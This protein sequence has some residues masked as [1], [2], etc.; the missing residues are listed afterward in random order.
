MRHSNLFLTTLLAPLVLC[1]ANIP[2]QDTPAWI[3]STGGTINW[4]RTTSAGALVACN[5][6]GLIG[7][8]P[9]SGKIAWTIHELAGA[10]ETGYE[11]VA[12]TPFI[13]IVPA[14]GPD[15]LFIVEPFSGT[16]LFNSM[17]AGINSIVSK[18][19]LY[20]ND[21]IVLVG[22]NS[23]AKPVMVCVDMTTGSVRWTKDS[24]FSRLSACT[25]AG[26][27]AM[28]VGT[29]FYAYKL[30]ARSGDVLWRRCPDPKFG[31]MTSL[32]SALDENGVKLAPD[33]EPQAVFVTTEHAPDLCFMAMQTTKKT[34][35]TDG[36]GKTSM[37]TTYSTF[38]NA[39]R[40]TDGSYAWEKPLQ[41]NNRS[42]TII[43]L[44]RGLLVGAADRGTIDMLDYTTG[45]GL[46]G[47]NGRGIN[48]KGPLSGAVEI[49]ATTLLNSGD[50]NAMTILV[51]ASGEDLWKKPVKLA[52]SMRRVI[53]RK[54]SV[55]ISTTEE[56]DL[57]GLTT[58]ESLI[59]GPFEGGDGLVAQKDGDTYLFNT[60]TGLLYAMSSGTNAVNALSSAPLEFEGKEKPTDLEL[61]DAGYVIGSDQNLALIGKDGAVKFKKYVPA[62]R[63]PGLTRAL[64]YA[65]AVRAAYYTAA[66]G[67]TSAAFGSVS[68]NI[69]VTDASSAAARDVT[70][71]V[72]EVYGDAAKTGMDAT[73]RFLQEA[74]ARF[75]ATA[76][77]SDV[78]FMLTDLGKRQYALK[79]VSKKDGSELATIPVGKDKT[80][81]YEVDGFTNTVYLTD[82][83]EVKAFHVK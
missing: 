60:R 40:I 1:S 78:Q 82:G 62:V 81:Q 79:A 66:F 43:P 18:Y 57:I 76:S 34:Q 16:V 30:D 15:Q 63:E 58:G 14:N 70:G 47:K 37:E 4:L 11:E 75:K 59:D 13:T 50:K 21:A 69:Q 2:A 46:W 80:P 24:G 39:F 12:N 54:G 23:A 71:A 83:A 52:G 48:V 77:T 27:D 38:V 55:L 36:Q 53:L 61:T 42:G 33:M 41:F 45:N 68:Q 17:S 19:F 51:D 56:A 72:S 7:L 31:S 32:F 3:S 49:G 10:S 65:S 5:A 74:N 8:D 73:K 9:E 67:Y 64:K 22:R 20:A 44:S 28:L 29:L 35:R 25:S 6:D 26:P